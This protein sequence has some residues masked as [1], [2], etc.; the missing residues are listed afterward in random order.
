MQCAHCTPKILCTR[1]LQKT[2]VNTEC[3][4][5]KQRHDI[6]NYIFHTLYNTNQLI[7]YK[8]LQPQ[9][10]EARAVAWIEVSHN[11]KLYA[12]HYDY[13]QKAAEMHNAYF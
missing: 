12:S 13:L 3:E 11:L 9:D 1:I 7:Q 10:G 4:W 8:F 5:Y 6:V 2:E